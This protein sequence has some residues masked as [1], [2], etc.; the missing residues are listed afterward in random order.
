MNFPAK[1]I[2]FYFILISN[3]FHEGATQTFG[4]VAGG[5]IAETVDVSFVVIAPIA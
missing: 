3:F 5:T 1:I 2:G 4:L